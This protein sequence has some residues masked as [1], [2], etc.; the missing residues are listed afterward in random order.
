M[1][2]TTFEKNKFRLPDFI[3][4]GAA[5]SGTT[6]MYRVLSRHP[7][8]FFP[9]NRKEPFYFS[10]GDN[11]PAYSDRAFAD[12]LIWSTREYLDLYLDAS[13]NQFMGDA[14]TSYLYTH[15]EAIQNMRNLYGDQLHR[16]KVVIILRNP[17]HRAYSHYTYLVRNGFETRTFEEAISPEGID[18]WKLK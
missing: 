8:L 2:T 3:I 10:F 1:L 16:V 15:R 9:K 11:E 12:H 4:P 6:T 5:K 14:S 7:D 17:I 13:D 18:E